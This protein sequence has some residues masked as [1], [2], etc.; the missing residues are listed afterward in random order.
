M[1]ML[2]DRLITK[3]VPFPMPTNRITFTGSGQT[4]GNKEGMLRYYKD[5][6]WVRTAVT[7]IATA[8]GQVDW[9]LY[10]LHKDG[11]R[12]EVD[13]H[14]LLDL[15]NKPNPFQSGHEFRELHQVFTEL[16][17]ECYHIKQMNKGTKELWI[18]PAQYMSAISD[19]VN[20]ISG[21]KYERE[22]VV[23][24]FKP[25][26]VIAFLEVNPL[27]QLEG[28]GRAQS[29]A[30]E[31]ESMSM[32]AQYNRNFFYWDA[33]AGTVITYPTEASITPDELNRLADQWNAGHRSYGRAHR[34]AILTQGATLSQT[35]SNNKDM[36]FVNLS[37]DVRNKILGAFGISYANVGGTE[38][39][40]RANAEAQ[41]LNFARGV[42]VPRLVKMREKWNMFLTPDY[43]EDLMLDFDNPVP[44][45]TEAQAQVIDNHVKASVISIEEARQ[46]LDLGDIMPDEHFMVPMQ[47]QVMNG[48]DLLSQKPVDP[49]AQPALPP[50][51]GFPPTKAVQKKSLY[52]ARKRLKT[53]IGSSS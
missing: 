24:L 46:L 50:G 27:N 42:M 10:K 14:E 53:I 38:S 45:D 20:Y 26:E 16:L 35:A 7:T 8:V 19:P 18:A 48:A 41:L 11:D 5:I 12:E 22:S 17:G 29:A 30:I 28:V 47:F 33:S 44:E 2:V 6:V 34:A 15:I 36:D 21:Y 49:N 32:M 31:I 52:L 1:G 9:R 39:I 3:A 25:E 37:A 4:T 51:G 13:S 23:K 40:N 43:G